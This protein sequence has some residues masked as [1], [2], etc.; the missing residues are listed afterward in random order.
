MNRS[1]W[2]YRSGLLAWSLLLWTLGFCVPILTGLLNRAVLDKLQGTSTLSVGLWPLFGAL[3]VLAVVQPLLLQLWLWVHLTFETTV[4]ALVRSNLFD[5]IL[6]SAGRRRERP[7]PAVLVGHLRDDVPGVTDLLNEWYRL[8]GEALFVVIALAIMIRIDALVALLTF[9]P[10]AV[11]VLVTHWMRARLPRLWAESREATTAVTTMVGDVFAGVHTVKAAGAE[12]AV[13]GRMATLNE[14]RRRAEVRLRVA[15]TRIEA[16]TDAIVAV[17]QGLVL[18]LAAGAMLSGRFTAGD[19][20]LF[21][22]YLSWML[23]LPRRM[24]R[25]LSQRKESGRAAQR[26]SETMGDTPVVTLVRHRPVY[27]LSEPP[28]VPAPRRTDADRLDELTVTGL[29][30]QQPGGEQSLR[31]VQL[32][33]RRG[34]VTVVTGEVGAGKSTLLEVLLGLRTAD[35]GEIRWNGVLVADPAAFMTPPRVAYKPQVPRLFAGSLRDN[36]LLGQPDHPG[37]L[38]RALHRAAF[39]EDVAGFTDGL[40]TVVGTRGVRLSGGQL[41]RASAARMFVREPELYV[42]DDLF[43]ALDEETERLVWQRLDGARTAGAAGTYLMVSHR[44]AALRRADQ[45]VVLDRGRVR[46]SGTLDELRESSPDLRRILGAP[47]NDHI[48]V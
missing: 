2:T 19:F 20:T 42:I 32:V 13:L 38:E 10:L 37:R 5:W 34:T 18:L 43:S 46:A 4:E 40:D 14:T 45:I 3:V 16:L 11:V 1:L 29:C 30:Y 24:G 15:T 26:L 48:G 8:S 12:S 31:D 25:L 35:S 44:P 41:Q 6:R 9:V 22:L 33:L 47:G 17:G 36:V 28:P 39:D 21:T 27:V 23:M 7:R